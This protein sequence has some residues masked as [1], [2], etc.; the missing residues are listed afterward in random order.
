M[1]SY[2]DWESSPEFELL[3][4]ILYEGV[5]QEDLT[6]QELHDAIIEAG[7][8]DTWESADILIDGQGELVLEVIDVDGESHRFSV[9]AVEDYMNDIYEWLE[10]QDVDFDVKY[11]PD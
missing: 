3:E 4:D 11:E 1:T 7:P 10:D 5:A 2:Y 9:G 8:P 6:E